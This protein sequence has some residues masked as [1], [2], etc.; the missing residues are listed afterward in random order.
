M[1]TALLDPRDILDDLDTLT[2]EALDHSTIADIHQVL[3]MAAAYC[4]RGDNPPVTAEA[5]ILEA[6][7]T[8]IGPTGEGD[9]VAQQA[10]AAVDRVPGYRTNLDLTPAAAAIR[11]ADRLA[12]AHPFVSHR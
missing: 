5:A 4:D 9:Y 8:L 2:A 3:T 1:T 11:A 7:L 12:A 6:A 10:R